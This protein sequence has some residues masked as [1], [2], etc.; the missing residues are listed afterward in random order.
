M[1]ACD[2]GAIVTVAKNLVRREFSSTPST[3]REEGTFPHCK[4]PDPQSHP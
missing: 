2:T 1:K 4:S 3:P